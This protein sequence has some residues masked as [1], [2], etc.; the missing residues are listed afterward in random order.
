MSEKYCMNCGTLLP[1]SANFCFKCGKK[2]EMIKEIKD[3][4]KDKPIT[5]MI[6]DFEKKIDEKI[7]EEGFS[8]GI[9][10]QLNNSPNSKSFKINKIITMSL[11]PRPDGITKRIILS[12]NKECHKKNKEM[13]DDF[14]YFTANLILGIS[15]IKWN[16]IFPN[17]R[18]LDAYEPYSYNGYSMSTLNISD[19]TLIFSLLNADAIRKPK[20]ID[21][22]YEFPMK[23]STYKKY[24]DSYIKENLFET[25]VEKTKLFE[26]N[27]SGLYYYFPLKVTMLFLYDSSD[28]LKQVSV[29]GKPG[30]GIIGSGEL[31]GKL[32][33]CAANIFDIDK[34]IDYTEKIYDLNKKNIFTAQWG[35]QNWGRFSMKKHYENNWLW[36]TIY[37]LILIPKK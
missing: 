23:F 17:I 10:F 5:I 16:S 8:K 9:T 30:T 1:E 13:F 11:V 19:Y 36:Y 4:E 26:N 22:K 31:F 21:Y 14:V 37:P 25:P 24:I 12:I 20:G 27:I 3:I 33:I 15:N 29:G 32:A 7:K 34:D 28:I 18:D 6:E 2:Q 35:L